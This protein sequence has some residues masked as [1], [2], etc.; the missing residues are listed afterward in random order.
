VK[1]L[2]FACS[3]AL[4]STLTVVAAC[5]QSQGDRCQV[6]EDCESG[7]LC[8]Q[9]KNTCQAMSAGDLDAS[10]IDAVPADAMVDGGVDSNV[11]AMIDAP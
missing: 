2:L 6:N 7:L 5:K 9:A 10:A 4:V 8:N 1:R 3:L 11:D